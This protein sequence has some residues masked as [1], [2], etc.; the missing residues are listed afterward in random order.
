M[1]THY[2]YNKI[3]KI[4]KEILEDSELTSKD[5]IRILGIIL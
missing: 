5:K 2:Y 3:L 1:E 4:I